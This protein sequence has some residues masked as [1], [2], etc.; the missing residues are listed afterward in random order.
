MLF[1]RAV[2]CLINIYPTGLFYMSW[3]VASDQFRQFFYCEDVINSKPIYGVLTRPK[4]R[5]KHVSTHNKHQEKNTF[6]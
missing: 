2:F 3:F 5:P 1:R 4:I 6:S